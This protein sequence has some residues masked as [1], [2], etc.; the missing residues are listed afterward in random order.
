MNK[1]LIVEDEQAIADMI[2]LCLGKNGYVCE[3]V[4]DGRIASE[5]IEE[6]RYDLILLDIML[7][8]IDGYDLIEYI[9]QFDIP[10]IFVSA[11]TSVADRVKG[12]KLGAEDYISKP[13]ELEELLARIETVLRRYHKVENIIEIGRIKIDTLQHIVLLDGNPVPLPIKE[14]ELLLFLVKNK[15]IALYRETIFEQVWQ[16]TYLGNT[17]TIDL[18]IQRLKKKLD[19]GDAIEAIYKVGYK[20][21]WSD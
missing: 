2:K 12:L 13:F 11:K 16:E 4:N 3:I 10:V 18:H 6:K 15:N 20:F 21:K 1:I 8:D 5:K 19:L 7:P 14:Y 17:R 9:K